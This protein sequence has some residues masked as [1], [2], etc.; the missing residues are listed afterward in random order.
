MNL[1]KLKSGFELPYIVR[2]QDFVLMV[3]WKSPNRSYHCKVLKETRELEITTTYTAISP[4]ILHELL[5]RNANGQPVM[6]IDTP[7]DLGEIKH[8]I[9]LPHEAVHE[10][11]WGVVDS[12]Y[13][14]GV[15]LNKKKVLEETKMMQ[16]LN[17]QDWFIPIGMTLPF[18]YQSLSTT[19]LQ[20]LPPVPEMLNPPTPQLT[21]PAPTIPQPQPQPQPKH[22][23]HH[24]SNQ[25]KHHH[26]NQ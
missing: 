1:M 21:L 7:S 23:K 24:H 15:W 25:K 20:L 13:F 11:N 14:I 4:Y 26:S 6:G 17:P 12:N 8:T 16:S 3:W 19:T 9:P 22:T 5:E 18:S 2:T 10:G